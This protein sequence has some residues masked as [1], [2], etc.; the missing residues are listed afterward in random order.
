MFVQSIS[1]EG[2]LDDAFSLVSDDFTYWTN[3][4]C[5]EYN[6]AEFRRIIENVKARAT[7]GFHLI[8]CLNE[9]QNTVIEAQADGVTV[10]GVRYD[11]PLVFIFDTRDGLITSLREYG[12][13][14]LALEAFGPRP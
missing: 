10:D 9:A 4:T 13:T 3:V 11:A 14:R 5:R 6:A 2:D 8:R 12:D 1:S 7:I